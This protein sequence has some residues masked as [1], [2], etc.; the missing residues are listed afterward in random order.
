MP[1]K[2]LN[3]CSRIFGKKYGQNMK[4]KKKFRIWKLWLSVGDGYME[5]KYKKT[6][7]SGFKPNTILKR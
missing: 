3:P 2:M 6:S 1:R 5:K 7:E 4:I